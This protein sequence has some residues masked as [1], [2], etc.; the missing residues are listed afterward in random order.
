[1][2]ILP[3]LTERQPHS[4]PI[5]AAVQRPLNL[6]AARIAVLGVM[7]SELTDYH[8]RMRERR[9]FLVWLGPVLLVVGI[10]LSGAA[11]LLGIAS[12]TPSGMCQQTPPTR[13][14]GTLQHSTNSSL[15]CERI[16]G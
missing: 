12:P 1:M 7:Q 16:G 5:V 15:T 4:N 11:S 14:A 2:E 6:Q 9:R 3:G 8:A 13:H 10:V